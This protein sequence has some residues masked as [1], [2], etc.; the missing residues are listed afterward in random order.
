MKY[1]VA[2]KYYGP[3]IR[4]NDWSQDKG[5]LVAAGGMLHLLGEKETETSLAYYPMPSIGGDIAVSL[6]FHF[7]RFD[8]DSEFCVKFNSIPKLAS[9]DA[10]FRFVINHGSYAFFYKQ[11]KVFEREM[12]A[13]RFFRP[14]TIKLATLMDEY[15][16][17]I[18][19]KLVV[20]G[21][22]DKPYT[23]NEGVFGVNIKKGD[24][25]IISFLEEYINYDLKIPEWKRG[26]LL[27]EEKFGRRSLNTNW[28]INGES[29]EPEDDAFTFNFMSNCVLKKK[30]KAPLAVDFK[31]TPMKSPLHYVAGVT[32]AIFI[33][34]VDKPKGDLFHY[35]ENLPDAGLPRLDQL[36]FYWA[37]FGGSNNVTTRMRKNPCRHL[38]RQFVDR[39][40]LLERNR[41]YDITLV[42]NDSFIEYWVDGKPWIRSYDPYALKSGHMGFR[43]YLSDLRISDLKVWKVS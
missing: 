35:L 19:G 16:F 28:L 27:Y 21:K 9:E 29:A 31:A 18:D 2:E 37:D 1:R 22:I 43:A 6:R 40:R 42:Q 20:K 25:R 32:D 3:E 13:I 14:H 26:E 8:Q 36:A 12:M 30:F 34:M 38:I 24:A 5:R 39:P 10:G 33:W 15:A 23:D 4:H 41:T 7:E 17:F 11:K